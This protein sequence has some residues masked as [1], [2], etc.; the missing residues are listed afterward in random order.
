MTYLDLVPVI[1]IL[2][3]LYA[4]RLH[5]IGTSGKYSLIILIPAVAPIL[6]MSLIFLQGTPNANSYGDLRRGEEVARQIIM[7]L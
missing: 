5:D 4:R 6:G 7:A 1:L 3:T 2:S